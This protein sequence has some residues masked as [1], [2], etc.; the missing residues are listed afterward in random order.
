M[1]CRRA[2][3]AVPP[4]VGHRGVRRYGRLVNAAP[5]GSWST[6]LTSQLLVETAA[7]VGELQLAQDGAL[8]WAESR[9]SEGGRVALVRRSTDGEVADMVPSGVNVRTRVHEY[10]GAAWCLVG[11]DPWYVDFADQRLYRIEPGQAPVA[12]T[13]EPDLP[14]GDRFADGRAE[15]GGDGVT[16]VRERHTDDGRVSNEIVTVGADGR[17][18]VLVSGPDFVSDPRW[19]AAGNSLCWLQW[20]HPNMPWDGTELVVRTA[21]GSEHVIAG[22]V[23]ESIS[24][25]TWAADGTLYFLSDRSGWWNLYRWTDRAQSGGS[26]EPVLVL[27]AEIGRPQWV[28]GLSRFALLEDGRIMAAACRDSF[29]RLHV[30]DVDGS[31]R[32]LDLPYSVYG[33]LRAITGG[34]VCVAG[35]PSTEPAVVEISADHGDVRVLSAARDLGLGQRWFAV[36]EPLSFPSGPD[37]RTAHALVYPPTNP[38]ASAPEG[39]LPPLL[40]KIH[41]GPTA[42]AQPLLDLSVQYWTTRG[43]VVAD[44]NYGGSTGYGRPYRDLLRDSWGVVDVEDC[45]AAAKALAVAGR[46]DPARMAITGGSAGGYTTLAVMTFAPGVFSAGASHYGV[47]DLA[48]LAAD[49]HKFESRYLDRL[50][51]PL[52]ESEALYDQRSPIKHANRLQTPLAVFQGLEDRVVPP[53][54][55]EVL[56][57]ALASNEVPHAAVFFAG[58]QHGFRKAENIRAALD[59]ELSFYAQIFGFELPADEGI[60]PI[61]IRRPPAGD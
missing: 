56:V 26:I 53:E 28:F 23:D 14:A 57:S 21:A 7:R 29:D 3:A 13:G 48:L 5:Y 45:V 27:E 34:V 46:V 15:S 36:P 60:T 50:V 4:W 52:P 37:G 43:F 38:D 12:V 19:S 58:E 2:A 1:I 20:N 33:Q 41:G 61:E 51:G 59:G 10:G 8:W 18:E 40:V 49:T 22:G 17:V 54:Q 6:P 25:P 30:V 31:S 24:Q 9:P 39:E 55:A 47:A 11:S 44:V 42:M 16:C 35:S 32:E